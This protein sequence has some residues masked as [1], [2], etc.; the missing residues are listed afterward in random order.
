MNE[1]DWRSQKRGARVTLFEVQAAI[2][3]LLK[4]GKKTSTRTIRAVIGHGSLDKISQLKKQ[5]LEDS[6]EDAIK[7]KTENDIKDSLNNSTK[8]IKDNIKNILTR[9]EDVETRLGKAGS[10]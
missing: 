10:L 6:L 2:E 7:D 8:D 1:R 3:K 5:A 4:E 9:L